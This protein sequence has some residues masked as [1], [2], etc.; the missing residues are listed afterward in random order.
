MID[1]SATEQSRALSAGHISSVD[2]IRETLGRIESNDAAIGAYAEIDVHGAL[3]QA[4]E[5]DQ[6]RRNGYGLSALDGI[7][8]AVKANLAVAGMEWS[9]GIA[10]R[11]GRVAPADA[12]AV[13]RLRALG[14]VV[15]GTTNLAEAA[16]G[17][18]TDNPI[19]GAT[20]SPAAPGHHAGGSS[21]GS[22]AAVASG[23]A[24]IALGSDTMGSIRIPAAFCGVVGWKPSPGLIP[25]EGLVPLSEQL[26]TVG[27]LTRTASDLRF[28]AL[29]SGWIDGAPPAPDRLSVPVDLLERCDTAVIERFRAALEGVP[30]KDVVLGIDPEEVRR[31][32]LLMVEVGAL[33]FHRDDLAADP[34]GFSRR[35]RTLLAYA[36]SASP[37][38]VE[39]ARL[40]LEGCRRQV[41]ATLHEVGILALPAVPVTPPPLLEPEWAG[42]ADLTAFVNAARCCAT[43]IPVPGP[44]GPVGLQLVM[45]TGMDATLLPK[46][47]MLEAAVNGM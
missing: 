21:G 47:V 17:A 10:A 40:R 41:E 45:N 20:S 28:V 7:P 22:A 11:R 46:S 27:V 24:A 16:I 35:L 25:V 23:M 12:A 8:M 13:A 4:E 34:A 31:A 30:T 15:I 29:E 3:R 32:G 33:A 44:G 2:L 39:R 14:V 6:R 37:E 1:Q 18:V 42:L 36:E 26:D 19:F 5:S 38:K 9:A 43:V